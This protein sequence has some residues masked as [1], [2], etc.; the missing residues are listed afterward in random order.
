MIIRNNLNLLK[1][2]PVLLLF[3]ACNQN[4]GDSE[5]DSKEAK[6]SIEWWGNM[7]D[8]DS[9]FLY[10]LKNDRGSVVTISNYGGIVTSF[11]VKDKNDKLSSVVVGLPSLEDYLEHPPYFGAII[12]RYANRIANAGFELDGQ[13]Y[14]IDK[15]DGANS[16]HGGDK[17]FDK[18]IWKTVVTDDSLPS[19]TCSYQSKDGEGG[20]PGN[21]DVN[22]VYTLTNDN[23]LRIEYFAKTDKATPINLTNHSYFNLTGDVTNSILDHKLWIDG[24]RYTPVNQAL[25]PT[26]QLAD[27]KG[28]PFDFTTAKQIGQDIDNVDGGY[29]HNWVLNEPNGT[30]R[31]VAILSDSISGRS[32]EVYTTEPGLQFYA[33]NFLDGKFKDDNGKP[34][35]Y[36]TALCLETQHFP[37]SPN[38]PSF[39]STILLP[40]NEYRSA[41]VYKIG[42]MK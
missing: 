3:V 37:D 13:K 14:E 10:T 24:N 38:Q 19:V 34:I 27:V 17:G 28:T 21:V 35:A 7:P 20:Y 22:V 39:P 26:G 5:M 16:L 15:N 29:D 42:L 41:T 1:C 25:I 23:E 11:Q 12:G 18:R 8:G 32:L 33:G 31:K 30:L 36:R 2:F 6:V 9:V 40:G 4:G